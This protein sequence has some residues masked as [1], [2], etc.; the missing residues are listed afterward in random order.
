[1]ASSVHT[2]RGLK[3]FVLSLGPYSIGLWEVLACMGGMLGLYL[4]LRMFSVL[5]LRFYALPPR[6]SGDPDQQRANYRVPVHM[7]VEISWEGAA[8]RF[9]GQAVDIS[10]GGAT[11]Q[12]RLPHPPPS[13]LSVRFPGEKQLGELRTQVVRMQSSQELRQYTLHCLFLAPTTAQEQ[14]LL[15]MVAS[16]ERALIQAY[17]EALAHGSR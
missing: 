8:T 10:A 7:D 9:T 12:I 15:H 11:L 17:P 13:L 5:T 14:H 16:R 1:M 4:L 6:L 2:L 3:A